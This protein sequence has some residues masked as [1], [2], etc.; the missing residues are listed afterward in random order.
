MGDIEGPDVKADI[1]GPDV[2]VSADIEGPD[3]DIDLKGKKKGFGGFGLKMPSFH[4]GGGAKGDVDVDMPEGNLHGDGKIDLDGG[5]E[6]EGPDIKADID[7]PDVD[8]SANIGGPDVD[9]SGGADLKGKKKGFG[10]GMKMPSLHGPKFGGK[11]KGDVDVEMPDAHLGGD[12]KIDMD[13]EGP[14]IKADIDGPDVDVSANIKGPD[15]DISG[16]ADIK[17]KKKGFGF[18]M[19]SFHGPKFHGPKGKVKGDVDVDMPEGHLHG[20]GKI[21]LDGG[22]DVEGPDIKAD[23]DGPDLDV[24]AQVEGPDVSGDMDLDGKKKGFGFGINLPSIHGPNFGGKVKGDVDAEMP[25]A[26][27]HGD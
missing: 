9:L 24:C 5:V 21:D 15:A 13:I 26:N 20:D 10:F 23:I 16:E 11:A 4:L 7:G 17:G 18:K 2:D 25:D 19:P 22:V 27:L 6:V 8:V 3:A 14:D 12:G 1:D